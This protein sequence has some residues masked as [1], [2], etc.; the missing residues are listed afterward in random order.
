MTDEFA[1][2]QQIPDIV[3]IIANE[4]V[5][6]FQQLH[7]LKVINRL[8]AADITWQLPA[9]TDNHSINKLPLADK[10]FVNTGTLSN[11]SRNAAKLKL[12]EL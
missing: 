7:N 4:I 5:T 1:N 6:F 9:I 3:P 12:Q 11:I 10:I 2:L 8:I